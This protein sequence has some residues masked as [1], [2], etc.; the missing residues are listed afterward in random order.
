MNHGF[1]V[2]NL[3]RLEQKVKENLKPKSNEKLEKTKK[4]FQCPKCDQR[5]YEKFNLEKHISF[6][7]EGKNHFKCSFCDYRSG[8]EARLASHISI[9]HEKNKP[10]K[11][12]SCE[13]S[14]AHNKRLKNHVK[15]IH[16]KNQK[17]EIT[18]LEHHFCRICYEKFPSKVL[19]WKHTLST[20][21]LKEKIDDTHWPSKETKEYPEENELKSNEERA[22]GDSVKASNENHLFCVLCNI[23]FHGSTHLVDHF[24]IVHK[25]MK[26]F[27]CSFC[28][29]ITGRVE[30][31]E[32]FPKKV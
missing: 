30:S 13:L 17:I 8:N 9:A 10:F 3:K 16:D 25:G 6:D 29:F 31:V 24:S 26:P 27:K 28:D 1:S 18:N 14:F 22:F 4:K 20:H 2:H 5:F 21:K 23:K 7:H 19:L 11:C 15:R 32:E 12:L